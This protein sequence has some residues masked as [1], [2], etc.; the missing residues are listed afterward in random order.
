VLTVDFVQAIREFGVPYY[1]KVDIEGAD[2]SCLEA[3]LEFESRPIYV[4]IESEKRDWSALEEEFDL[5]ESL[6]YRQFAVCQQSGIGRH[7]IVCHT[8]TGDDLRIRF[9]E[10]CSGPFGDDLTEAW[11]DRAGALDRY[12][13]IFH[14]YKLLGDSS[15]LGRT[16]PGRVVRQTLSK[17]L[18]RPLPGWYDTHARR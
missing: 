5:L 3:L 18:R 16:R 6:G 7:E 12:R 11:V 10:G 15:L 17:L 1:M 13:E 8:R 14:H 4:S 9:P 2:R